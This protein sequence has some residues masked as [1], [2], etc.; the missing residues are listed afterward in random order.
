[1]AT[2]RDPCVTEGSGEAAA[3]TQRAW[4]VPTLASGDF[5][6]RGPR[7]A[8]TA[9]AGGGGRGR[10]QANSTLCAVRGAC[11]P[12]E[13]TRVRGAFSWLAS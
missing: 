3:T 6:R 2:W 12:G 10:R 1:M 4:A 9:D 11:A 13:A 5:G 7:P 8:R